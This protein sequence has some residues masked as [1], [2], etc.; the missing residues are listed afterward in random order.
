MDSMIS[1]REYFVQALLVSSHLFSEVG[2]LEAFEQVSA[3]GHSSY[4]MCHGILSIFLLEIIDCF[5]DI[6]RD[7]DGGVYDAFY[8]SGVQVL[9]IV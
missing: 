6:F 9:R 8:V 4:N 2:V 1:L 7:G 5:Q 3:F